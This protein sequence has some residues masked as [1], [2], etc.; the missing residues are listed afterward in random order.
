MVLG[1]WDL[2]PWGGGEGGRAGH[3]QADIHSSEIKVGPASPSW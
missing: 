3:R 2:G 1:V